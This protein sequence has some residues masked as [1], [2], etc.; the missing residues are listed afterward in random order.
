MNMMPKGERVRRAVRWISECLKSDSSQAV[1]PL[2]RE[3]A[4]RFDLT[5]KESEELIQFYRSVREH[6]GGSGA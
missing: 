4:V 1:M 6:E 2:A 5:P 3:A